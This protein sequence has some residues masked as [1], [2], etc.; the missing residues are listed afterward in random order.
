MSK[1]IRRILILNV[2][3]VM[4]VIISPYLSSVEAYKPHI[5]SAL[6]RTLGRDVTISQL[7]FSL[8]PLPHLEGT[9]VTIF[10]ARQK[11]EM[12][13]SKISIRPELK[14]LLDGQLILNHVHFSGIS[15]NQLLLESYLED[16]QTPLP[17]RNTDALLRVKRISGSAVTVRLNDNSLVGPL[18]FDTHFA[19]AQKFTSLTVA[20]TDRSLAVTLKPAGQS[21]HFAAQGQQFVPL[22][23]PPV[24]FDT[25]IASGRY[26]AGKV[27]VDNL[28]SNFYGGM[29]TG[30]GTL[31][32]SDND[33]KLSAHLS[34]DAVELAPV[35]RLFADQYVSGAVSGDFDI[36]LA[37]QDFASL[38]H[39]PVVE[40]N[41]SVAN[42]TFDN[43]DNG[44]SVIRF[45]RLQAKGTLTRDGARFRQ[46]ALDGYGGQLT[47]HDASVSWRQD[48]SVN[49]RLHAHNVDLDQFASLFTEDKVIKGQL[50]GRVLLKLAAKTPAQ[51]LD[52]PFLDGELTVKQGQIFSAGNPDA[53]SPD[54]KP[55][56]TFAEGRTRAV[57]QGPADQPVIKGNLELEHIRLHDD[58]DPALTLLEF[59][60]ASGANIVDFQKRSWQFSDVSLTGYK[61]ELISE[62]LLMDWQG[63]WRLSGKLVTRNIELAALT[64]GLFDK[65][66]VNGML[67]SNLEFSLE[68]DAFSQLFDHPQVSGVFFLNDGQFYDPHEQHDEGKHAFVTFSELSGKLDLQKE[69][70]H[71]PLL[72]MKAYD[73]TLN[74]ANTTFTWEDGLLLETQAWAARVDVA[75]LLE[76]FT[77]EKPVEGRFSGD[78]AIKLAGNTLEDMLAD[79]FVIVNFSI[80]DGLIRNADLK[81][82]SRTLGRKKHSGGRTEFKKLNGRMIMKDNKVRISNCRLESDNMVASI[83]LRI[84]ENNAVEGVADVGLKE[85]SGLVSMPMVISGT[86]H[87]PQLAP[88]GGAMLGGAIGTSVLGPGLGTLV[89]VQTGRVLTGLGKIFTHTKDKAEQEEAFE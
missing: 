9:N 23:G 62:K 26:T 68:N 29:V 13:I 42:G 1:L 69:Q 84:A 80:D 71:F 28:E 8:F 56:L 74:T 76:G 66:Y 7:R 43:P 17:D 54:K 47:A 70:V 33:W 87:E 36:K 73:G 63:Q 2:L 14:K 16:W 18:R 79:P 19:A 86:M 65:Q 83:K 4:A 22:Y 58:M 27:I 44:E 51:L 24:R 57:F 61:G 15:T 34:T 49:T 37:G 25:F 45:S 46:L 75:P 10:S 50:T 85:I 41:F 89:G 3:L 11:G 38:T 20:M 6:S 88:T 39:N 67:D 40:G 59:N 81:E 21:L 52:R 48:W 12:V 60:T 30:E 78:A 32:W 53:P 31:T 55:V 72:V 77:D 82:A 35:N 64:A 5:E